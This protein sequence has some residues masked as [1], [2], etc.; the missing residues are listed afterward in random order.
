MRTCIFKHNISDLVSLVTKYLDFETLH[1]YFRH[2]SNKVIC[3]VLDNIEDM[4]KIHFLTQ[5]YIC[6]SYIL[7]KTH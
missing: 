5:T 1:H 3:H 4:K 7:G 2:I 6:Y